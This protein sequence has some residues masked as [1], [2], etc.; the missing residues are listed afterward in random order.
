MQ[1]DEKVDK[2]AKL[3]TDIHL[4]S[5]TLTSVAG[6]CALMYSEIVKTKGIKTIFEMGFLKSELPDA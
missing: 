5:P 3:D 4:L 6:Y 2:K 1:V